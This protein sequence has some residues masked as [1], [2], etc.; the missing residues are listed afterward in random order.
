MNNNKDKN[1]NF[2]TSFAS[3][4]ASMHSKNNTPSKPFDYRGY[5]PNH[6]PASHNPYPYDPN[7]YPTSQYSYSGASYR[8]YNPTF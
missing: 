6:N 3:P 7:F 4:K 1:S 8:S 5:N 2:N